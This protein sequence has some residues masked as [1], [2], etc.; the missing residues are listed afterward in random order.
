MQK[1]AGPTGGASK[2]Q[3]HGMHSRK[4]VRN[5]AW[6]FDNSSLLKR[7]KRPR[8]VHIILHFSRTMMCHSL[9]LG[10]GSAPLDRHER[11]KRV[12]WC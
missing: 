12:E 10:L 6:L 4:W 8:P 7:V 3:P 5:T 11:E 9:S 2:S 1:A